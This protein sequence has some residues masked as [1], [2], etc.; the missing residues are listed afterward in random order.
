VTGWKDL[1]LARKAD[2]G[3]LVAPYLREMDAAATA[4]PR[5]AA[6]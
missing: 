1:P 5:E 4:S 3:N 2:Y 6:D